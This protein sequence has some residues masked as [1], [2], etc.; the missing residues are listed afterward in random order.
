VITILSLTWPEYT[1]RAVI[2]IGLKT[3][4]FNACDERMR[5]EITLI[6]ST[7]SRVIEKDSTKTEHTISSDE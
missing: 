2:T 3:V 5:A 1:L 6:E 7:I 4:K